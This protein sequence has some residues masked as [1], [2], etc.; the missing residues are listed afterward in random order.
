MRDLKLVEIL[1]CEGD[2][3]VPR[4]VNLVTHVLEELHVDADIHLVEIEPADTLERRFL[5]SPTVRVDGADVEP[6]AD[7]STE[8]A[9]GGRIYQTRG[10]P[11][12]QPEKTWIRAALAV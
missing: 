10:G 2:P 3:S 12:S 11:A 9:F 5:G 4:T 7:D 6:G 1:Y 8:Y